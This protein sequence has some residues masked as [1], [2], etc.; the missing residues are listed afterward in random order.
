V[1]ASASRAAENHLQVV[2]ISNFG[3]I[4]IGVIDVSG[5]PSYAMSITWKLHK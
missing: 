3:V 5:Q 2:A 1:K 4:T